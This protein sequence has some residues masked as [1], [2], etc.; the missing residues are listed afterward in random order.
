VSDRPIEFPVEGLCDGVVR[1]R[2][3]AEAD[4]PAIVAA[5]Q[6]PQIPRWTRVPEPYAEADARSWFEQEATQRS[7]GQQLGLLIV[8]PDRDRLLGSVGIAHSDWTEGRCELG[9]WVAR[10]ARGRGVGT[11]AVRLLTSW[12][13]EALAIDRVEICAE[14]ENTGSRRVA[15]RAGFTFE[16]VMRSYIVNK[17][18][19]RDMT[20]YSRLRSDAA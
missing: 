9:Y 20:M 17:G 2:L 7:R 11:R 18:T 10:E 13:F 6:D 14:P 5:C 1:L 4:L 15:E 8:D 16:G 3:M 12:I 19:R